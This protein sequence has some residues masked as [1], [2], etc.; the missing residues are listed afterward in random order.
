VLAPD[1]DA[2]YVVIHVRAGI[3]SEK[4]YEDAVLAVGACGEG[5]EGGSFSRS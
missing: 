5:I 2:G 4:F 1:Y 3:G